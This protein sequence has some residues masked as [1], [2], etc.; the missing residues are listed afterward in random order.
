MGKIH[1]LLK[2]ISDMKEKDVSKISQDE[3]EAK[4][5]DMKDD[6][7]KKI[8]ERKS[9]AAGNAEALVDLSALSS[10]MGINVKKEEVSEA[11][12]QPERLPEDGQLKS[13]GDIKEDNNNLKDVLSAAELV[14]DNLLTRIRRKDKSV[15]VP[16]EKLEEETK[17]PEKE[18]DEKRRA[19]F[20][21][22]ASWELTCL[23]NAV[24]HRLPL[25]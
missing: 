20:A 17:R 9:G 14:R 23:H 19:N 15:S 6:I 1:R 18:K 24:K 3:K 25:S 10:R 7:L 8:R 11:P 4:I 21:A 16:E 22:C 5:S 12:P 13:S 2:K